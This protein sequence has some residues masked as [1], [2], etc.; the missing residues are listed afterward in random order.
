V[1]LLHAAAAVIVDDV[2]N[3]DYA[4]LVAAAIVHSEDALLVDTAIV[5]E[6]IYSN[7]FL[8]DARI[9]VINDVDYRQ[10]PLF[11]VD[12]VDSV[13]WGYCC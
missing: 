2:V 3:S 11:V 8:L 4:L 13:C 10:S 7:V 1:T 12:V 6:V 5:V 9:M